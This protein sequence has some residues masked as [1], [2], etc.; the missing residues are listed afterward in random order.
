VKLSLPGGTAG[1]PMLSA[2]GSDVYVL[3]SQN[4]ASAKPMQIYFSASSDNGIHF[5]TPVVIDTTTTL[6]SLTPVVAS[7]GSN[8]VVG[9]TA[10]VHSY[11]R[12]SLNGGGTWGSVLSLSSNHE[13]QVA[14]SGN[15][16]YAISDGGHFA[17]SHDAGSTWTMKS[18][19]TDSE[20]WIAA[21]G[22]NVYAAWETKSTSS[23]VWVLVS[24]DDGNTF[25]TKV[26]TTTLP[27]S[28][29]PMVAAFGSEAYVAIQEYP[30]VSKANI[31]I[32]VSSNSG[33]SWSAPVSLSG[34]GSILSYPFNIATS[35]G[36]NVFVMWG[37]QVSSGNWASRVS[38]SADGGT[39]WT[40]APGIN[41]SNNPSGAAATNNDIATGSIASD[42]THGLAVW[43]YVSGTSSQV[44]STAS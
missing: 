22:S 43:Q 44:Y 31:W 20:P 38:Y 24:N 30:G 42:G 15:N 27:N 16:V 10:S 40:T 7:Y 23:K 29:N 26:L 1:Y 39:T 32:Y 19:G 11:I 18:I 33:R 21:S 5:S 28:W 8:I 13:P 41:V 2:V 36:I 9:W 4:T 12:T 34:S 35:D 14:I 25:A 6:S 3:W 17:V 37:Q